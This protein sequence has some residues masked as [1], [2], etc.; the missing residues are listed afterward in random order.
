M[1]TGFTGSIVSWITPNGA[2]PTHMAALQ[3]DSFPPPYR[4]LTEQTACRRVQHSPP[5]GIQGYIQRFLF[6]MLPKDLKITPSVLNN[7]VD[8]TEELRKDK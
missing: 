7:C 5:T 2:G 4:S 8:G 6:L 3:A 1:L